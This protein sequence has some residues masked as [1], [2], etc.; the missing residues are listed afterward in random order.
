[1]EEFLFLS[2]LSSSNVAS[3][4]SE[5]LRRQVMLNAIIYHRFNSD[6]VAIVELVLGG[7]VIGNLQ[8][9]P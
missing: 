3:L 8:Q 6:G 1:M 4:S 7:V 2:R 5:V 9:L